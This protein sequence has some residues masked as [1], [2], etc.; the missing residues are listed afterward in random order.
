MLVYNRDAHL[1]LGER[2]GNPGVWQF[3]QGG[4]EPDASLEENVIRELEEELG[5]QRHV[6]GTLTK[7]N[8]T[9][10]YDFAR[11]PD[12]AVGV[13]RG[14]AQTFW[15]VQFLGV[16]SD[17]VLDAHAP[18]FMNWQ[19]CPVDDVRLKAE[20]RR[21]TGYGPALDEFQALLQAGRLP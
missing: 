13:W 2:H 6:I 15:L 4:V 11:I 5:L 3:P 12:Y 10:Q 21:I 20:P 8:A 9:H 16:D 14:Q 19:W 1:F 17:I 18:E 7:L